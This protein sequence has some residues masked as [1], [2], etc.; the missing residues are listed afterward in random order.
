[1]PT[2]IRHYSNLRDES[3]ARRID[4]IGSIIRAGVWHPTRDHFY[5]S[6][7]V[8][9]SRAKHIVRRKRFSAVFRGWMLEFWVTVFDARQ[10]ASAFASAYIG[11]NFHFA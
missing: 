8:Y 4:G 2:P 7:V 3:L 6:G 9:E 1:M 10:H 11:L 5:F